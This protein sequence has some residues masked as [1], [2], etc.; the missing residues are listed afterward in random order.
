MEV[1]VPQSWED[2]LSHLSSFPLKDSL[3]MHALV[4]S[5]LNL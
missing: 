3:P 1:L 2:D 5:V 4:T